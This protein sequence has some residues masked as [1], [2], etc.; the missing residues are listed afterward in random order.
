MLH[1]ATA[2]RTSDHARDEPSRRSAPALA[3]PP[4]TAPGPGRHWVGELEADTT[5]T[6]STSSS[7]ISLGRVG[8]D[9]ERRSSRYLRERQCPTGLEPLRG[10]ATADLSATIKAYFAMKMAGVPVDDPAMAA[11]RAPDLE[12]G[13][14]TEANV[15][16]KIPLAL[17]GEY[18]WSG[19]P[20]MP[21]EIMLLPR[22]SYFNLLEVSYWSRTVI[23]PLL[24]LMDAKPVKLRAATSAGSTSCG[25]SARE[26][27]ASTIPRC[28]PPAAGSSSGRTCS[29]A[30]TA[31]SRGGSA[32][33]PRPCEVARSRRPGAGWRSAWRC[34]AAWA[35]SIPPWPTPSSRCGLGYPEDHR[36]DPGQIK[37]IEAL[38]VESRAASTTS[39]ASRRSGTPRWPLNALLAVRRCRPITRPLLRAADWIIDGR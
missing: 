7:V 19:V 20:A 4:A 32:L 18:D 36:A 31:A 14:P 2:C 1:Y 35:A 22:W 34:R 12:R 15:F 13:G 21:V 38:G 24:I 39:P 26:P 37:E 33:G 23:V 10:R 16:T 27:P 3:G 30:W 29:S 25:R 6:A 9:R 5:I 8:P 17:F 11:A 28:L